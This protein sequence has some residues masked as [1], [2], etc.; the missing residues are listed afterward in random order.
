MR[1]QNI[2]EIFKNK[3]CHVKIMPWIIE[4]AMLILA[5]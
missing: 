1:V 4:A 5:G 3:P 2:V